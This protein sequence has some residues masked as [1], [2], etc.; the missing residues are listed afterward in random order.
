LYVIN[1]TE[2]GSVV[3]NK[4]I[5]LNFNLSQVYKAIVTP[6]NNE[7]IIVG[8]SGKVSNKNGMCFIKI[9]TDGNLIW[10]YKKAFGVWENYAND[11][12]IIGNDNYIITGYYDK[13]TTVDYNYQ[14]YALNINGDG[15]SLKL[16]TNGASK[17]DYCI[18][19]VYSPTQDNLIMV[20]MEGR[21]RNTE[22]LSL[23][24]IKIL[25]VNTSLTS[26]VSDNLYA[27]VQACQAMG[28][29]KN[30]DG[31]LSIIG[32]KYAYDNKNIVHAFF[33]KIKPDGTF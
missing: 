24:N 33:M 17:Q 8:N 27:H 26:V 22:D 16:F 23:A 10:Q 5:K 21:G 3:W 15:D 4:K 18:S 31:S 11:I 12:Q 30:T 9:D 6:S 28:A 25:T 20:G 7:I 14:F 19:S 1:T 2:N 29:I 13:S 32:K